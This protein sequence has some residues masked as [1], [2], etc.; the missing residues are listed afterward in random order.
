[1]PDLPFPVV[2]AEWKFTRSTSHCSPEEQEYQPLIKSGCSI[3]AY[4]ATS[5]GTAGLFIEYKDQAGTKIVGVTCGHVL[6]KVGDSVCQPSEHDFAVF[7]ARLEARK[8]H[9]EEVLKAVP[10]HQRPKL[11]QLNSEIT[12]IDS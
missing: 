4:G 3:G 9:L 7:E 5:S 12:H 10:P 2:V 6:D 1:M 11:S 8:K